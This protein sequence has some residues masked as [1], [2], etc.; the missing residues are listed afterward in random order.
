[1]AIRRIYCDSCGKTVPLLDPEDVAN[2]WHSRT[3][4]ITAQKPPDHHITVT[5]Y[6]AGESPK[7]VRTDLPT[8]L[9]DRCC[10]VIPDGAPAI[11]YTAWRGST[12]PPVWETDY[13]AKPKL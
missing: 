6:N 7:P 5:K 3:V 13:A 10:Q 2:H 12:E 8:L 9:C 1:M 4:S 11:A